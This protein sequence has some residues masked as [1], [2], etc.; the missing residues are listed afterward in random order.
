MSARSLSKHFR[1]AFFLASGVT[2]LCMMPGIVSA[3]PQDRKTTVTF[4]APVEIPGVGAQVLPAGTYVFRLLDSK[5]TRHVVQVLDKDESKI[6]ATILTLPNYRLKATDQTVMTFTE[7]PAGD[8]QAIK[9]WFYPGD[10][11]GQEFVYSKTRAVALAAATHEPVLYVADDVA[12]NIVAPAPT[13]TS[14]PVTALK[15]APVKAVGPTGQDIPVG[16]VVQAPA[17][18]A[19]ASSPAPAPAPAPAKLPHTAGNVPLLALIGILC[20]GLSFGLGRS[21]SLCAR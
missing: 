17:A 8:P 14:P 2:A 1:R 11:I 10:S 15:T 4:T 16:D 12:T 21:R 5:D 19:S 20:L 6:F 13:A 7:R 9:A 18:Q 3:Q